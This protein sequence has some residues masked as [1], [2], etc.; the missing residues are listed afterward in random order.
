MTRRLL[1]QFGVAALGLVLT[2]GMAFADSTDNAANP[3]TPP[4]QPGQTS[5]LNTNNVTNVNDSTSNNQNLGGGIDI[6]NNDSNSSG[7]SGA[8]LANTPPATQPTNP[9]ADTSSVTNPATEPVPPAGN[10]Q[11]PPTGGTTSP[12]PPPSI[13][14]DGTPTA[15]IGTDQP[16]SIA[17]AVRRAAAAVASNPTDQPE[18]I[19]TTAPS[20]PQQSTP[21]LP[22]APVGF[23][24][25]LPLLMTQVVVPII[26][27]LPLAAFPVALTASLVAA[28][29]LFTQPVSRFATSTYTARLRR[30]GFLGAARSDVGAAILS[31]ATPR[32]MSFIYAYAT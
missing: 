23:L 24:A 10:D 26:H 21:G 20:L 30:S 5:S 19:A 2:T 32:E 31:F 29:F 22:H 17:T 18:L 15:S 25:Q 7:D 9:E 8:N 4:V 12:T 3:S 6:N 14:T 11:N 27:D 13:N 16:V 1:V 28:L